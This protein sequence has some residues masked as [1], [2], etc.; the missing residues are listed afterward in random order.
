M[1][2]R[3][4]IISA[5]LLVGAAYRVHATESE[6]VVPRESLNAVPLQIAQWRG[7]NEPGFASNILAQLGVDEYLNR[8]YNDGRQPWIS[9][10]VGFYGSQRQGDTIHSPLNCMPGAGWEAVKQDRATFEVKGADGIARPITVNE[11]IIQKGLDRQVVHYW[12]QSHGRVVASEY[13]SKVFMV[14]DAI[15][16]NRT[17]AAMVRVI[18]PIT[19]KDA[20]TGETATLRARQFVQELFPS[21][22]RVLPS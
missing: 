22:T 2:S 7:R 15:R 17:D 21:L 12:Y 5:V 19:S 20:A 14:Y 11:F 9:L 4:F 18:T 6:V 13:T 8:I 16:L 3:I 10:Y 1:I